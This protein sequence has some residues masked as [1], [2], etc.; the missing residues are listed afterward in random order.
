M[1]IVINMIITFYKKFSL[2]HH[3]TTSF[4]PVSNRD[5]TGLVAGCRLPVCSFVVGCRMSVLFGTLFNA[6]LKTHNFSTESP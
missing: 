5:G 1:V 4:N 6:Q 2:S 3:L